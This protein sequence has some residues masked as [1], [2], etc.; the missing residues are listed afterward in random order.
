[1]NEQDLFDNVRKGPP[2]VS[3]DKVRKMV[4]SFPVASAPFDWSSIINLN[5]IVMSSITAFI[6]AGSMMLYSGDSEGDGLTTTTYQIV[7]DTEQV[8]NL[9]PLLDQDTQTTATEAQDILPP[10]EPEIEDPIEEPASPKVTIPTPP[11]EVTEPEVEIAVE[12]EIPEVPEA[13]ATPEVE[14]ESDVFVEIDMHE[15]TEE[16]RAKVWE[17]NW[18]K[19]CEDEHSHKS[20]C[21]DGKAASFTMSE[22]RKEFQVGKFH[23]VNLAGS[24]DMHVTQGNTHSVYAEG[25]DEILEKLEV[26]EKDGHLKIRTQ[27]MKDWKSYKGKSMTIYVT[28]PDFESMSL[29]GSGAIQIGDFSNLKG[30]NL[31]IAGSGSINAE[32]ELTMS[33]YSEFHIAG[34]GDM[35][36]D[37][38]APDLEIHIAGSGDFKGSDLRTGTAEIHIAGSGDVHI[39]CETELEAHIAGSG[40]VIYRGSP[41]V[42]SKV[43]GSGSVNKEN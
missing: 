10:E 27:K 17:K 4:V 40:D 2:E 23:S 15:R 37:G 25:D 3:M 13:P 32:G 31:S 20:S 6:L 26:I 33:D 34:S 43:V 12:S 22:G 11:E 7:P 28:M 16:I 36:V 14:V 39:H 41:Q 30:I 18:K 9:T 42:E 19:D 35:N 24:W 21:S 29:S 1:M 8:E 38:S 5:T